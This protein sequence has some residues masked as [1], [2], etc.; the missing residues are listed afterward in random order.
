M[1]APGGQ[2]I[3]YERYSPEILK[4]RQRPIDSIIIFTRLNVKKFA[5][6]AGIVKRAIIKI[7]P[8][9]F[10]RRTIAILIIDK[11]KK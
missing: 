6:D 3:K 5:I 2:K 10:V 11:S 1:L 4:T 8:V 9:I 7:I